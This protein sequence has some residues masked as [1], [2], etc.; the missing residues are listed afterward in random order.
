MRVVICGPP[1]FI[2]VEF[3]E[4]IITVRV[5]RSMMSTK[6]RYRTQKCQVILGAFVTRNRGTHLPTFSTCD[7]KRILL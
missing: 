7:V 5:A 6:I 3:L 1:T 2:M 4:E